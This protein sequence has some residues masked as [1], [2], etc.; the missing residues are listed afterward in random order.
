MPCFIYLSR[1]RDTWTTKIVLSSGKGRLITTDKGWWYRRACRELG[2]EWRH[3]TFGRR[4]AVKRL[5]FPTKHRLKSFY[6]P[7][8]HSGGLI[9]TSSL[10]KMCLALFLPSYSHFRI[11]PT[12]SAHLDNL[13]N[14]FKLIE[15]H[16]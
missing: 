11:F 15:S 7:P 9:L 16:F 3:E 6:I 4:N 12:G 1:R 14:I 13:S 10:L 8:L 5:F 2:L